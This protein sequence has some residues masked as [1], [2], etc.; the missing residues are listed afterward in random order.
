MPVNELFHGP[1]QALA[2]PSS[3]LLCETDLLDP[4]EVGRVMQDADGI[5]RWYL[6]NLALWWRTFIAEDVP[7]PRVPE[8][9]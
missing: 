3:A 5:K 4:R 1:L 2:S 6:L 7:A 8:H 9:A